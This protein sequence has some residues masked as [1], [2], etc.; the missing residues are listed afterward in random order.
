MEHGD[1]GYGL[2]IAAAIGFWESTFGLG[3]HGQWVIWVERGFW[4]LKRGGA[5]RTA[6]IGMLR[7]L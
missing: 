3:G 4:E 7:Y 6:T 1:G 5:W 2:W